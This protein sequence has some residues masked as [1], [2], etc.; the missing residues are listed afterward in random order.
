MD[1]K[2]LTVSGNAN[3]AERNGYVG[4]FTTWKRIGATNYE[5]SVYFSPE[6]GESLEDKITRMVQSEALNC[7]A[8]RL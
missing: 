4:P 8:K 2:E 5:V 1:V 6:S 7:G 3:Q